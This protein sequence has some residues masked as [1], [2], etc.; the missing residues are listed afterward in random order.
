MMEER[1]IAL[2]QAVRDI[3]AKLLENRPRTIPGY[4]S[5]GGVVEI[6]DPD[7]ASDAPKKD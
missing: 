4:D 3:K 6:P 1:L 7:E 5:K 2:E